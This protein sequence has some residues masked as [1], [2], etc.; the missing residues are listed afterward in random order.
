[1]DFAQT[2]EHLMHADTPLKPSLLYNLS[3]L[4]PE[5]HACVIAIW[6]SIP[7]PRRHA[8]VKQLVEIA[9]TNF[10]VDFESIFRLGLRDD[11]AEVRATSVEG[12]WEVEDLALMDELLD[13]LH[14]DLS[15]RVRAAAALSLG[16]YLLLS[17]LGKLPA[18]RCR[19]VYEM[20]RDIILDIGEDLDVQRRALESIA[21]VSHNDVITMLQ[22]A[23]DHPEE[24]MRVS[25]VFGMGRSADE[26]WIEIVMG[27]LFNVN[28]EMRYEAAR[29]CGELQA[30]VA[31]PRLAELL[32]DPDREVQEAAVWALGQTGGKEARRLLEI[33]FEEGDEVIRHAAEEALQE[34]EFFFDQFDFPFYTVDDIEADLTL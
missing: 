17:E 34:L 6:P 13:L 10:E 12:L 23:Y 4:E 3:K 11:D 32:D 20:M 28:P 19:P 8:L 2:L 26:R 25:A 29:A 9:E 14:K 15:V 21:Y 22:D 5:E 16:R 30:R 7:A 33:C 31:V 24:K 27:E 1:M 18:E